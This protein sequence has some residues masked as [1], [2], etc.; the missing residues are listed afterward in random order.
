MAS[1]ASRLFPQGSLVVVQ[2]RPLY[3]S[4]AELQLFNLHVHTAIAET[5]A[6]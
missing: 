6:Y 2:P 1:L 4:R 3:T 5:D